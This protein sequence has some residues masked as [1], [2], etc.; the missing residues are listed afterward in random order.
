MLNLSS[1]FSDVAWPLTIVLAWIAGEFG[2]RWIKLPRISIY[3][4]VGFLL[5]DSQFGFLP[6]TEQGSMLLLA[7]IAFGLILFEFGYRINIRWFYS[8]PWI[9]FA[10]FIE[11][12]VTFFTVFI[13]AHNYGVTTIQALLLASLAMSTSPAGIMRV[14]NEQK[15]SGQVTERLLHLTAINCILAVFAF[16]VIVGFALFSSSGSVWEA[17]SN[18]LLILLCS[19][20]LGG[21]FGILIPSTMRRLER[22]A[23]DGTI[24]FALTVILLVA[25]THAA[26]LSPILATLT[27]GLVARNRRVVLN[28]TQRNFGA[29]GELLTVLLFVFGVSTLE[30]QKVLAG[31]ALGIMLI[32]VRMVTKTLSVAIFASASGISW[33]KGALTGL[34]LAPISVFVILVLEQARYLGISFVDELAS[35]AAMTLFMEI[36]GPIITQRVLVWAKEISGAA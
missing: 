33:R 4:L 17:I 10:G 5:A 8:N 18:S 9:G 20:L 13:I 24:A 11:A 6:N 3:G 31:S 23:P 16:K 36:I 7:N 12:V 29:L 30:W 2:A 34:G 27:F 19:A 35:L 1:L 21:I 28:Q 15:S 32:A 26:K 14:I 25:I 22:L